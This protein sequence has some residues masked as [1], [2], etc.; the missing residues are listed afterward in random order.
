MVSLLVLSNLVVLGVWWTIDS[1]E[2][3]FR[4]NAERLEDVVPELAARPTAASEPLYFMVIGSD[5]REGVDASVFGD[6]AGARSDVVMVARLDRDQSR[7]QLLSFPRDTLVPIEG[8]GEGKINAAY[9]YGGAALMVKTVR[10]A[11]DL[12]IHHYVEVDFAGFQALVDELGGVEMTFAHP[13]RDGKSH[14]EVPAGT[15][16]LDGYQALAFARSRSYEELQGDSWRRVDANDI[17]RTQRQQALVLAI[18]ETLKRPSTLT[19]TGSIVASIAEHMTVDAALADSSLAE[20]AFSLR[21]I[22]GSD[23][24]TATVP[25]EDATHSGASVQIL[26]QPAAH[27]MLAAF[28]SGGPLEE[29]GEEA[30]LSIDVLNGNGV[31]GSAS[32]WAARLGGV[33]YRVNR[34]DDAA[35]RL[36]ETVV[37]VGAEHAGAATGLISDL[38][39]GTVEVG[40]VPQGVDAVVILGEDAGMPVS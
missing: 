25:T 2:L 22:E 19:E 15:V 12:P 7:V 20:L 16:I 36:E 30:I 11:F 35:E 17:G 39:F 24:E 27:S 9:A 34:I 31:T 40:L 10:Q 26:R 4:N 1:A 28:R 38:G 37:L 18:L 5:S 29:G 6:F 8:N 21:G 13:A 33:G 23:I 3:A 32:E 14:L